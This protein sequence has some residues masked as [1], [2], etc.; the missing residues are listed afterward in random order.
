M[1]WAAVVGEM[2]SVTTLPPGCRRGLE[3]LSKEF[4]KDVTDECGYHGDF[5][6][7]NRKNISDCPNDTPL[8]P[9][10]RALK[11]SHQKVGIK[12]EDNKSHLD[13]RSPDIF[14]HGKYDSSAEPAGCLA[15][16]SAR[17][18]TPRPEPPVL[19]IGSAQSLPTPERFRRSAW[20]AVTRPVQAPRSRY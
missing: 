3:F 8:P 16:R 2:D 14:L 13:H 4:K 9:H 19:A 17:P 5:K 6:I 15:T 20:A 18:P 11:F 7:G 1:A 12:Q 10:S